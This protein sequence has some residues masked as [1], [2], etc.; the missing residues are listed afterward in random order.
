MYK[1][2]S[3]TLRTIFDSNLSVN[4]K[5]ALAEWLLIQDIITLDDYREFM[6]LL[7]PK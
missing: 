6:N 3:L 7:L 2:F 4:C 1:E 5:R